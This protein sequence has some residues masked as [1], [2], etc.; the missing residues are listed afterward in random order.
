M[1]LVR[2]PKP[3]T[4]FA[5]E[6]T[7]P[8]PCH[9]VKWENPRTEGLVQG[10]TAGIKPRESLTTHSRTFLPQ[11]KHLTCSLSY[12]KTQAEA[13]FTSAARAADR[14]WGLVKGVWVQ[15]QKSLETVRSYSQGMDQL[16]WDAVTPS[17]SSSCLPLYLPP[18][19]PSWGA[20]QKLNRCLGYT[21]GLSSPQN[22]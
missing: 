14:R 5:L 17:L 6:R 20:H 22:Q 16:L 1:L 19:L 12:T 15:I 3:L 13:W 2:L 4:Y 11:G 18:T 21:L 10:H 9:L 7:Q 8:L